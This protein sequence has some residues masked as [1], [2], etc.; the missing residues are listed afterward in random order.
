MPRLNVFQCSV[1]GGTVY[2]TD[3]FVL[4]PTIPEWSISPIGFPPGT[5]KI[6]YN[7][8]VN[9]DGDGDRILVTDNNVKAWVMETASGLW[10][11]VATRSQKGNQ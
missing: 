3:F 8:A 5:P 9:L 11:H 6:Y 2:L 1:P 7:C 10:T 4:D